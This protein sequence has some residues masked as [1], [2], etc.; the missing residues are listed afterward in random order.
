MSMCDDF[1]NSFDVTGARLVENGAVGD[2]TLEERVI[3]G[4][5]DELFED[6][7]LDFRDFVTGARDD[8]NGTVG[9]R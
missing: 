8:E 1:A 9:L 5:F 3:E 4:K 6:L 7:S 2:E